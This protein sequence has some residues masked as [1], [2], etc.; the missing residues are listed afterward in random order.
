MVCSVQGRP[1]KTRQVK[2][3]VKSMLIIF[4]DIKEIVHKEQRIASEDYYCDV[5]QKLHENV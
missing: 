1:K 2:C 5:L 4:F 3:K